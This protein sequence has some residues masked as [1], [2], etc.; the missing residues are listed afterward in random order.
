MPEGTDS[1]HR[2]YH[3]GPFRF[4][5]TR[6]ELFKDG[7]PVELPRR[8][9]RAL[10]LLIE[11]HGR[12]LD[13]A[14]LM[15]QLWP[16][17]V[18]EEKNL[19]VI[20]SMLRKV[21]GDDVE[22]KK[23]ILTNP[24]RGY[25]FVAE[26][27]KVAPG[28]LPHAVGQLGAAAESTATPR[29]GFR[30]RHG[31]TLPRF[32]LA[33]GLALLIAFLGIHEWSEYHTAQ[34]IAV[35]PFRAVGPESDDGYLGLAMADG[36][37]ARLRSIRHVTV[38]P[39]TEVIR[40]RTT[41]YDAP[42]L[43]RDLQV[44]SLLEGTVQ[45]SGDQVWLRVKLVRV[46]DGAVLW[47]SDYHGESADILSFQD[48]IAD[49][50]ARALALKLGSAEQQGMHRHY[51]SNSGAY[52][53][54]VQGRSYCG[55]PRVTD[56]ER[57]ISYL[58]E[59]AARDPQFALAQ[60]SLAICYAELSSGSP[61]ATELF[62]KAE[63]AAQQAL[64][65]DGDLPEAYLARGLV[66]A[67]CDWDF[68]GAA[69]AFRRSIDLEPKD[70]KTHIVYAEF[71]I[72]QGRFNE[73]EA[74]ANQGLELDPFSWDAYVTISE[75]YFFG[76]HYQQATERW[77]KAGAGGLDEGSWYLA[78]IDASQGRPIAITGELLKAEKTPGKQWIAASGLAYVSALQGKRSQTE[79]YLAERSRYMDPLGDYYIA[80][81]YAALGD[82]DEAFRH[83]LLARQKRSR[84]LLQLNVDP[85]LGNLRSDPRFGELLRSIHLSS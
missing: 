39:M 42:A 78:W 4:D 83:L 65:I 24:G 72:G 40:Y 60:A 56:R 73:A 77:E 5:T 14:Y 33:G 52:V 41:T 58:Q 63:R 74:E 82:R 55:G 13:K 30:Q 15:E 18:V 59:A 81:I 68:A 61:D 29:P 22:H 34:A 21:L 71:L 84:D 79:G 3:F 36:L 67:Y 75:A 38:R 7:Q 85:R 49:Q 50:A 76:H 69:D 70:P 53:I 2:Y 43:G 48:R 31:M 47:S 27:T 46:K 64:A 11:N 19:T 45:R 17:T 80:L 51:T 57:G 54:Y 35:L 62:A 32:G 25:R 6:Q 20:I 16:K 28:E 12:D 44:S 37:I 9:A 1:N 66:K 8:L 23:Y 26:V 10:Q